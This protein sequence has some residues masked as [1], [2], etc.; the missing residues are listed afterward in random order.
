VWA[1]ARRRRDGG[2]SSER[3]WNGTSSTWCR[4]LPERGVGGKSSGGAVGVKSRGADSANDGRDWEANS[5]RPQLMHGKKREDVGAGLKCRPD[6]AEKAPARH[7]CPGITS[8]RLRDVSTLG[9][10]ANLNQLCA[11]T[12][13]RPVRHVGHSLHNGHVTHDPHGRR[14]Q[15][16]QRNG[17]ILEIKTPRA[18]LQ[19]TSGLEGY[20]RQ[21]RSRAPTG[22]TKGKNTTTLLL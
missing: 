19:L 4:Q 17:N 1:V 3:R 5:S 20:I 12:S 18:S 6:H 14:D 16:F 11:I 9:G 22:K 13:T 15:R 8:T 7:A 2:G 10:P 21:M